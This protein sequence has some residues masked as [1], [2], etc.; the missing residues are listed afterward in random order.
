MQEEPDCGHKCGFT[1][2]ARR[3]PAQWGTGRPAEPVCSFKLLP[4]GSGRLRVDVFNDLKGA[5]KVLLQ[6]CR[7]NPKTPRKG[8]SAFNAE[9]E[10]LSSFRFSHESLRRGLM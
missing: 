2:K 9:A 4:L 5:A 10:L 8:L 6:T 7:S 1:H 3:H